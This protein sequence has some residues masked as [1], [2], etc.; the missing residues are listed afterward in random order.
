LVYSLLI[1]KY[2]YYY[3]GT[4]IYLIFLYLQEKLG[5]TGGDAVP[6]MNE[7]NDTNGSHHEQ[8]EA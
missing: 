4:D 5:E 7:R 1:H 2:T 3:F 8:K 6:D